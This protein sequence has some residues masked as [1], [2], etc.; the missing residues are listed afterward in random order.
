MK[1][2]PRKIV[3][4]LKEEYGIEVTLRTILN[5]QQHNLISEPQRKSH[6]RGIGKT[7]EYPEDVIYEFLASYVVT[8]GPDVKFSQ[9][10]AGQARVLGLEILT[11]KWTRETF[12]AEFNSNLTG[13]FAAYHWL[14][15][16]ELARDGKLDFQDKSKPRYSVFYE[17]TE[18]GSLQRKIEKVPEGGTQQF[19]VKIG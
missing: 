16:W 1:L 2:N 4:K 11:R 15:N 13:F 5:Y 8:R 18:D 10:I 3:E 19:G 9:E 6:G 7:T 17:L 12:M 14:A